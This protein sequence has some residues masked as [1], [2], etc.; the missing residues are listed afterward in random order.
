M[1]GKGHLDKANELLSNYSNSESWNISIDSLKLYVSLLRTS[2]YLGNS[3]A[4]HELGFLYENEEF[5]GIKS[6]YYN[7]KRSIYWY[8]KSCCGGYGDG[9]VA[10]ANTFNLD[11]PEE[12]TKS[13]E[14]LTR[15][16]S[17]NGIN[18]AYNLFATFAYK[19]NYVD[20]Y[21]WLKLAI[22]QSPND[23]EALFKMGEFYY[24]GHSVKKS[25][26]KAFHYFCKAYKS[27]SITLYTEEVILYYLGR[28]Y[29]FGQYLQKSVAKAKYLIS[30]A[31]IDKDHSDIDEFIQLHPDLMAHPSVEKVK[32]YTL[33][34]IGK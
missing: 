14:V 11:N 18:A 8:N 30:K 33:D 27:D 3:E 6:T 7:P 34:K 9:C 1:K 13:I 28:M 24:W 25:Y 12:Y 17:L 29:Y 20:A 2:A 10:Y 31:N 5:R 23:G 32:I 4:Q 22:K 21:K 15:A 26:S 19:K 16:Y